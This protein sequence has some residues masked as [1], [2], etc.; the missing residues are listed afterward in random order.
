MSHPLLPAGI[1][2]ELER[3]RL[4]AAAEDLV[5]KFARCSNFSENT[6]WNPNSSQIGDYFA[7]CVKSRNL[8]DQIRAVKRQLISFVEELGVLDEQWR[9]QLH[10]YHPDIGNL[11]DQ[12]S[13]K[14]RPNQLQ[15]A[16]ETG[17]RI[18][19]RLTEIA[20]EYDDKIDECEMIAQNL[21][22]AMQTVRNPTLGLSFLTCTC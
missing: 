11:S 1:F 18:T 8:V 14:K 20:V 4:I 10:R 7:I 3:E 5:D 9:F 17:E 12:T 19:R 22:L 6:K 21:P 16:L 15:N 13:E 2:A